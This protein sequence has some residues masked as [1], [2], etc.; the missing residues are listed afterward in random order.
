MKFYAEF[1]RGVVL[2]ITVFTIYSFCVSQLGAQTQDV[3]LPDGKTIV[4][5]SLKATGADINFAKVKNVVTTIPSNGMEVQS[6]HYSAKPNK[7]YTKLE[8]PG[9]LKVVRGSNGTVAWELHSMNGPRI[10]KG[11]EKE[12]IMHFANLD[13]NNYE[14]LFQKI[15]CV[16]VEKVGIEDCYKVVLTPIK[17]KPYTVFYSKESGLELKIA[18]TVTTVRG[19]IPAEH[20]FSDY[21]SVNGLKYPFRTFEKALNAESIIKI[22]S[23][24]H[25]Q[26]LPANVFELPEEIKALLKKEKMD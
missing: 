15:E 19:E 10:I 16:G 21:Q 5:K 4:A 8:V 17:A 6:I 18:R 25:N 20:L 7:F 3:K 22:A 13:K 12:S 9:L 11:E 2:A 23:I 1:K 14:Q 24:K 26:E